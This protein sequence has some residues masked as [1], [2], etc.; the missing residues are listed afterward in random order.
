MTKEVN[1]TGSVQHYGARLSTTEPGYPGTTAEKTIEREIVIRFNYDNL[2]NYSST[3]ASVLSIPKGSVIVS[4]SLQVETA[5]AGG[6][7]YAVGLYDSAGNAIDA[8][9]LITDANAPVANINAQYKV[10]V[11]SG[12]LVGAVSSTSADGQIVVTATGTFTAGRAK[13]VVKYK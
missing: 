2:P 7:S 6:T 1:S 13:L 9:G 3:D 8:D 11:G 12:A 4:A 5:F 10:V